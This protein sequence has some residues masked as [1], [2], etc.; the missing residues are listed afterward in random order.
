MVDPYALKL[1]LFSISILTLTRFLATFYYEAN[2]YTKQSALVAL[3]TGLEPILGLINAC[4]PFL[5]SVLKRVG[6][7]TVF[8]RA[9]IILKSTARKY[10]KGQ[11]HCCYRQHR[12]P[13]L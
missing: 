12:G 5:H 8:I 9:S 1:I 11:G 3:I 13:V 10:L 6:Q 4:L 2:D 7:T